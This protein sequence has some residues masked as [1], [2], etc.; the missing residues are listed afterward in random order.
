ME[1]QEGTQGQRTELG[2]GSEGVGMT[3][4]TREVARA[5]HE[6]HQLRF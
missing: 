2:S 3:R 1:A 6:P 4:R 5:A